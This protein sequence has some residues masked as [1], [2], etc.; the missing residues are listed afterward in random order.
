[1]GLQLPLARRR[2]KSLV[3][4]HDRYRAGR[5]QRP[6]V[7]SR[8]DACEGFSTER[9]CGQGPAVCCSGREARRGDPAADVER[10]SGLLRRLS[11]AGGATERRFVGGGGGSALFRRRDAG[12]GPCRSGFLART[13]PRTWRLGT[14][15]TATG[16]QWDR[17][18]GWAPLQYLAIEGL[19]SYGERDLAREIAERWIGKNSSGYAA[20]GVLVEKYDVEQGDGSGSGG[21]GGGGGE[22]QLQIGFGWTNGVLAK[23]MAEYP[24]LASPALQERP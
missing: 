16:Q 22:Y 8:T 6:D 15:T 2:Q 10:E 14:T 20:A 24:E 1:M 13:P 3:D 21:G 23:L 7:S 17:P 19:N 4:P 18:N 12:R 11:L 9:R 5:S